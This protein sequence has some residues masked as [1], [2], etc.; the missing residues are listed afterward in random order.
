MNSVEL[1]LKILV[2][3]WEIGNGWKILT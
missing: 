1:G 2:D 3:S